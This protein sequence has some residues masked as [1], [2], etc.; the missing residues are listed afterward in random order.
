MAFCGAYSHSG[1]S[2][3]VTDFL[4]SAEQ[5]VRSEIKRVE[6]DIRPYV[7]QYVLPIVGTVVG[8]AL[9]PGIGTSIGMSAG[10]AGG[11]IGASV[12]GIAQTE[13]EKKEAIKDIE[14][15]ISQT[16]L[17]EQ[18]ILAATEATKKVQEGEQQV[19]QA[20]LFAKPSNLALMAMGIALVAYVPPLKKGGRGHGKRKGRPRRR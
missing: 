19:A 6:Q 4:K 18:Q 10:T 13:Y 1:F 20:G 9:L 12:V 2:S 15:Q 11:L 5:K 3:D 7:K 8:S 14:A 17:Y 16:Q